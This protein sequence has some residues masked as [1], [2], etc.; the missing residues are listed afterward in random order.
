MRFFREANVVIEAAKGPKG[1]ERIYRAQQAT[2]PAGLTRTGV[3]TSEYGAFKSKIGGRQDPLRD[4]KARSVR[5]TEI[6]LRNI[7]RIL[8]SNETFRK[9][10][11]SLLE[12]FAKTRK[13]IRSDQEHVLSY[14][15]GQIDRL[16]NQ[17]DRLKTI[18]AALEPQDKR[19]NQFKKEL[20]EAEEKHDM[21]KDELDQVFDQ[22]LEVIGQNEQSSLEY[23]EKVIDTCQKTAKEEFDK[24]AEHISTHEKPTMVFRTFEEI[25]SEL[26]DDETF[27][28]DLIRLEHLNLILSENEDENP[29]YVFFFLAGAKYD[30]TKGSDANFKKLVYRTQ[31]ITVE[32][33]WNR[34]PMSVFTFF[35]NNTKDDVPLRKLSGGR[36]KQVK[37]FQPINDILDIIKT[38]DDFDKYK[39]NL[40]EMIGAMD[41]DEGRHKAIDD[42]INGPF[43]RKGATAV[44]RL[45]GM[46]KGVLREA[47]LP[48]FESDDEYVGILAM[49]G[50]H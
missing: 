7:F 14:N 48:E 31:N 49:Y 39:F 26:I 44:Q 50:V 29:L 46:L 15:P 22:M 35:Y 19:V 25:E 43:L 11:D 2:G 27:D 10:L 23:Q 28:Q 4:T 42:I 20:Q 13:Q 30:E 33:L 40:K 3:G 9:R 34:L 8:K 12:K 38:E 36:R 45:K 1:G 41:L 6:V 37:A 17:I 18:I 5:K 24:L 16:F 47:V 21:Y 32:T